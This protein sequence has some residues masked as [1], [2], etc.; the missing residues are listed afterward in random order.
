MRSAV[1]AAGKA[2]PLRPVWITGTQNRVG[3]EVAL[4]VLPHHRTCVLSH[5]A[6]SRLVER[7]VTL[8]QGDESEA[9]K[10]GLVHG[11]LGSRGVAR[12]PPSTGA[13]RCG[14]C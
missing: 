8:H 14:P 5:P 1:V 10:P 9:I 2:S 3:G 11:G 12:A 4:P 13:C 6:V 7:R